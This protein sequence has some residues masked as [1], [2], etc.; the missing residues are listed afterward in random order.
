MRDHQTTM[1]GLDKIRRQVNFTT[2]VAAIALEN[3]QQ[4]WQGKFGEI[5]KGKDYSNKRI[6]EEVEKLKGGD[7][8]NMKKNP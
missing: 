3:T 1:I 5:E 6:L 7:I 2:R 8:S 4:L